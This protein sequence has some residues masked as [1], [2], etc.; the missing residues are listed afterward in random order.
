[1][2]KVVYL[3][4]L[5]VAVAYGIG[6]VRL[7]EMGA[8]RFLTNMEDLIQDG[9]ADEVCDL[10]HEDLEVEIVDSTG[11]TE[12]NLSGGKEEL[13][14]LTR[15]T[16]AGL[17][18]VPNSMKVSFTEVNAKHDWKHP[19]TGEISYLENRSLTINGTN[20]TIRTVSNDEI[21][22]VHTFS[23]VKLRKIRSEVYKADAT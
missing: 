3:V 21:T 12:N 18:L 9:K 23:G 17:N 11:G 5:V 8:L 2:K 7:G 1:M 4:I 13:C 20:V 14:E 19:W 22:L 10:Y 16:V 15:A 6:R